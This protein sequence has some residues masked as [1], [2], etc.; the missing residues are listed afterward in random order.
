MLQRDVQSRAA[1]YA[2]NAALF[3]NE[4]LPFVYHAHLLNGLESALKEKTVFSLAPVIELCEFL[5]S[6]QKD[7]FARQEFEPSLPAAKLAVVQFL[8]QL[9]KTKEPGAQ[10]SV[11]ER[12][13]RLT[14]SLLAQPEPLPYDEGGQGFDPATHSLNCV[15]G[16]AVHDLVGYAFY[17]DRKRGVGHRGASKPTM[18]PLVKDALTG[19]LAQSANPSLAVHSV[20]GWYFPQ[21]MYLDTDW[22]LQHKPDIFPSGDDKRAY[23]QAAWGAYISFAN[24]YRETFRVLVPEY[25][26]AL[27][28]LPATSHEKQTGRSDQQMASHI[29]KAYLMQLIELDSPDGLLSLYYESTDDE[30]RSHGNFWLSQFL[31]AQKPSAENEAWKRIWA[32]WQRRIGAAADSED[33]PKFQMEISSFSRLLD[34]V[35]V[36]LDV[37]APTLSDMIDFQ[38]HGHYEVL[39]IMEY[40]ARNAGRHVRQAVGLLHKIVS[41]NL[42][43]YLTEKNRQGI[44]DI[45]EQAKSSD[46]G[47]VRQ[48]AVE[49]INILG[50][51]GE[52]EWRSLLDELQ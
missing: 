39:K 26:R 38:G 2:E 1:L 27:Q 35:P 33:K 29:L 25:Q 40:I 42:L 22:A 36:E 16:V 24:V 52:Y 48:Q 43:P 46:D 9:F 12:C 5:A 44:R 7:D 4:A 11:I 18:T 34:N 10:D 3:A 19:Q 32:L 13:G 47:Q 41:N 23:W 49:I 30:T 15:Q 21:L 8:G 28:Q 31:Q 51:L 45:L 6:R 50:E 14:V 17:W 37:L 20:F